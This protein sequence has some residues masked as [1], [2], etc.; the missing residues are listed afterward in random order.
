MAEENRDWGYRRIQGALSTASCGSLIEDRWCADTLDSAPR[1]PLDRIYHS[2]GSPG[3]PLRPHPQHTIMTSSFRHHAA[4][5]RDLE[6][7][8]GL[9]WCASEKGRPLGTAW[10]EF[11]LCAI[12]LGDG[13]WGGRCMLA[14]EDRRKDQ[15]NPE[16]SANKS[17]W[18][19][20]RMARRPTKPSRPGRENAAC[21]YA[22]I[23]SI[24]SLWVDRLESQAGTPVHRIRS[25][26]SLA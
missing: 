12:Y 15:A 1:R 18:T 5:C 8:A 13:F 2:P 6:L 17:K 20:W 14:L 4:E 10:A 26:T 23:R 16:S 9:F 21:R 11:L 25:G 19:G 7:G 22:R 24:R 3:G